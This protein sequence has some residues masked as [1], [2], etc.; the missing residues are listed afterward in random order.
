MG[1]KLDSDE[2]EAFLDELVVADVGGVVP[3]LEGNGVP[4]EG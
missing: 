4:G 3:L 1:V 2:G